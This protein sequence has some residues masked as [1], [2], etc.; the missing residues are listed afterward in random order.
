MN[1]IRRTGKDLLTLIPTTIILIVPLSPV[2]HVLVFS[3][4]QVRY[5]RT[6][7]HSLQWRN[8]IFIFP[9]KFL[10]LWNEVRT[11]PLFY[12]VILRASTWH[13][14]S[15]GLHK[16]INFSL[17]RFFPD[18]FPSCY[19]EKRLNLRRLYAEIERKNDDD[20]LGEEEKSNEWELWTSPM[21]DS[22]KKFLTLYGLENFS[23]SF[24]SSTSNAEENDGT[25]N[26]DKL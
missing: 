8:Y 16:L 2:G 7:T 19:T 10:I 18:F 5:H 17:Q 3:F 9:F 1:A 23:R 6:L 20:I 4:I 24:I 12:K 22:L 14:F 26:V 13:L 21:S 25:D 11:D 15:P